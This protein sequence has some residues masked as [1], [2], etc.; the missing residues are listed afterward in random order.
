MSSRAEVGFCRTCKSLELAPSDKTGSFTC[1]ECTQ[2]KRKIF[3]RK[4]LEPEIEM[5]EAAASTKTS[6]KIKRIKAKETIEED[7]E[8]K[9][10]CSKKSHKL[11][12]KHAKE[13]IEQDEE[14]AATS[15]NMTA[16][17]LKPN[18]VKESI[19]VDETSAATS[20]KKISQVLKLN[21]FKSS[22]RAREA[23]KNAT[24]LNKLDPQKSRKVPSV[25]C[26]RSRPDVPDEGVFSAGAGEKIGRKNH[27]L[28]TMEGEL[29]CPI[30]L[31][32]FAKP[33]TLNEWYFILI[34]CS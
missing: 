17:R 24:G 16:H 18:K 32:L 23:L 31:E 14:F 3:S 29:T 12:L 6:H 7:D 10:T 30:C 5:D 1:L 8:S 13:S 15:S 26:E 34:M 25:L 27:V 28:E 33:V 21:E 22:I 20:S 4:G 9:A 11:K 19:E 2:S